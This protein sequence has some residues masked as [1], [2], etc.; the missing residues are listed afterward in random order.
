M[1]PLAHRVRR[2]LSPAR[3]AWLLGLGLLCAAVA[4]HLPAA[5]QG[6]ARLD[7]NASI[8]SILG[9]NERARLAGA[10]KRRLYNNTSYPWEQYAAWG[11]ELTVKGFVKAPPAGRGPSAPLA[12]EYRCVHCHNFAREDASL[13]A[14]DPEGREKRVRDAAYPEPQKR[15]GNV[16][17]L[18]PG[19]TL[20]GAVNRESFYNGAYEKYHKLP[21][22]G[23]RR[24]DPRSLADAI[25]L[26]S[27]FCSGG[28]YPLEW[29][30]DSLLAYLWELELRLCDLDLPKEKEEEVLRALNGTD[31]A[32]LTRARALVRS[33]YL[34]SAG[35]TKAEMPFRTMGAVTQYAGGK[36]VTGSAVRGKLLYLSACAGCHGSGLHPL[37]GAKLLDSN[38]QYHRLVLRGTE[39]DGLYMPFFASQRLSPRQL[40]DIRVYLNSLAK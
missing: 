5:A 36:D 10:L 22:A 31:A 26:C 9:N 28:R 11:R 12:K 15:D 19:T 32:A 4:P 21:V 33:S 8:D 30:L 18:T 1:Q 16:V 6:K 7:R 2:W 27:R 38:S 14:Q 17:S 39:R 3:S 37:E 34:R 13:T 40:A 29:E 20:W 25:Q 23:G 35:A 24:M